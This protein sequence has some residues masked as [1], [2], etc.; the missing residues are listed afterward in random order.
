MTS[1]AEERVARLLLEFVP[2][3]DDIVLVGGWVHALYL[4][5]LQ[6][7]GGVF[8]EDIDITVP[9]E[10]PCG[11]RPPLLALAERAG[12]ERDPISEM[13]GGGIWMVSANAD[14]ML[15]PIDFL[16]EGAPR[17]PIPIVGQPGLTAQGYPGQRILLEQTT[18]LAVGAAF[19][20]LLRRPVSVRVPTLGAYILQKGVAAGTRANA[21]KR[22]KDLVYLLE[23]VRH[24]TLGPIALAQWRALASRYAA[25]STTFHATITAALGDGRTLDDIVEQML[26]SGGRRGD[27]SVVRAE[28]RAWLRR[29][30][31]ES[32]TVD[33]AR[34]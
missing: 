9:R 10:L 4:A 30:Q 12:F 25:E 33:E 27:P 6:E 31:D 13:E 14:G 5:D 17:T 7:R 29:L 28:Q 3:L 32:S 19:H 8:T 22:A 18:R 26:L 21:Y 1:V 34:R 2:Y 24:P 20:A 23:I 16:T 11:S 15:V